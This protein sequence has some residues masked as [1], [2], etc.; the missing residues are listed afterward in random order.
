L[1]LQVENDRLLEEMSRGLFESLSSTETQVLELARLQ[2]TLQ[3]HLTHQHDLTCRLFEDSI[4]SVEET[5]RG[6]E[7]LR[8]NRESGATMRKFLVAAILGLSALLLMLHYFNK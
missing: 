7:Y 4:T 6:N 8:R 3:N 2:A 1:L 5:R